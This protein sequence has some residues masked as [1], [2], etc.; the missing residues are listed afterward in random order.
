M[1][2]AGEYGE[3]GEKPLAGRFRGCAFVGVLG[4]RVLV[5]DVGCLGSDAGFGVGGDGCSVLRLLFSA[6]AAIEFE[7]LI[8]RSM[9]RLDVAASCDAAREFVLNEFGGVTFILTVPWRSIWSS[10][11]SVHICVREGECGNGMSA[12]SSE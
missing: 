5:S 9:L 11:H 1:Y 8:S 10:F 7:S 3:C 2:S 4:V 12:R 6:A